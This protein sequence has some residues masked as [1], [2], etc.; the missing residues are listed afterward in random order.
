MFT[1][2]SGKIRL[3]DGTATPQYLELK[4]DAGDCDG[5]LGPPAWEETLVM[6]RG[7]MTA[8]AFY[9]KG[10]DEKKMEVVPV[11]FSA[12]ITHLAISG[13]LINWLRAM[14][15]AATT[16]INSNTI[17]TTKGTSQR[18]GVTCPPFAD[19]NK[20]ASDI[21]VFWDESGVDFGMKYQEC[22]I[23]LD[24]AKITESNESLVI[25]LPFQCYGNIEPITSFTV[26][27]DITS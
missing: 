16:Q 26:G 25:S 5:P 21:E 4:F 8:D 14:N 11:T 7:K 22:W 18:A 6:D 10:S 13:Y 27:T 9:K 17:V 19:S 1:N 12:L 23:P 15:D 24:Q 2:R 3:L 20:I